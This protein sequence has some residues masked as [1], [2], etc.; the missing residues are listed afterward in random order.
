MPNA[1]SYDHVLSFALDHPWAVTRPMLA[2]IAGILAHRIAG[3]DVDQAELQAA[4]VNRKN[5]PQPRAGSV[6][7]IPVYGVLAP[8]MNLM[9]E[10]SG[11]TTFEKLTAQL[12][13]AVAD[14]TIKTIVLDVDSPGG[15]VAGNTEFAR[16]VMQARAK[17]PVIAQAQYTMGSAAYRLGAAATEIVAAPSAHVGSIGV[18]NIHN[19]ISAALEKLGVK[20]TFVSAGDGK[21]VNNEAAP[22]SDQ[23]LA[24]MTTM[25]NE[26]YG[27]FVSDVVKGRGAGMTAD[28]VKKE[29][30]AHVYGAQEALALGMI[31]SIGTLDDTV[32]R[33]LAAS[34]DAADQRAAMEFLSPHAT[35]QE[36]LPATAQEREADRQWQHATDRTL[37]EFDL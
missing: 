7:I 8:R 17:K 36:P 26:A 22:L 37:L 34:P 23:G 19:D 27:H 31:D 6:A 35:A 33:V 13:A 21:E 32:A 5:L 24:R 2:I 9:S 18:F 4:L 15:S 14:K 3:V 16:E 10:M 11:G 25:V 29:W 20:R 1:R 28:R 30:K 12:R